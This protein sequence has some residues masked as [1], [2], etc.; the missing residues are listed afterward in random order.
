[1]RPA[2]KSVS[3]AS[4]LLLGGVLSFDFT[5]LVMAGDEPGLPRSDRGGVVAKVGNYQF[6]VFFYP[7]GVRV[8]PMTAAD[9]TVDVAR[10]TATA[11][12]FHPNSPRPWFSRPLHPRAVASTES[13]LDLVIGLSNAPASGAKVT[14]EVTGLPDQAKPSAAFTVP[15][16]F[17]VTPSAAQAVPPQGGVASVPRYTYGPGYEGYGYHP[18]TSPGPAMPSAAPFTT[19]GS[20]MRYNGAGHE[21]GPNHPRDWSTGRDSPLAK[22]WMKPMD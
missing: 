7:T 2:R 19:Y 17:V 6:E 3:L 21:V 22:P 13:S 18:Y 5:G 12:F 16:E 15:L 9:A 1:M 11:T 20:T 10:L 8:F 14:F 4:V